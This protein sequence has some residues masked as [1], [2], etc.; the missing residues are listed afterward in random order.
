[1][2]Q[3]DVAFNCFIK[4]YKTKYTMEKNEKNPKTKQNNKV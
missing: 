1:M 4:K 2:F 3:M